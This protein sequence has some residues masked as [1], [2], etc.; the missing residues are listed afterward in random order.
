MTLGTWVVGP[1]PFF[2]WVSAIVHMGFHAYPAAYFPFVGNVRF[3]KLAVFSFA[4]LSLSI[5]SVSAQ[6]KLPTVEEA[7][8]TSATTGRP[9]FAMAGQET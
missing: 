7:L 6:T 8:E 5:G 2:G 1:G 4:L 3:V 9:I